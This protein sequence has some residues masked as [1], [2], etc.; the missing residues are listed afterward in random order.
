[1]EEKKVDEKKLEEVTGGV[2]DQRTPFLTGDFV[3]RFQQKNCDSCAKD[4]PSCPYYCKT[5]KLYEAYGPS[6]YTCSERVA[7]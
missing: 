2:F 3:K 5:D 7:K 6:N 1:M 4:G